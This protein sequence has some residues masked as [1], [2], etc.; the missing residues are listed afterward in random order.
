M[1]FWGWESFV[2]NIVE[3]NFHLL[4]FCNV[5]YDGCIEDL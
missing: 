4:R 3:Y 5:L 2:R 1:E